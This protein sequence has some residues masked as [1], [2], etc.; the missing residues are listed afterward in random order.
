M[1][2]SPLRTIESQIADLK[3]AQ[4]AFESFG[5]AMARLAEMLLKMIEDV[6]RKFH[7]RLPGS[8]RTA[9]LRKKRR[10]KLIQWWEEEIWRRSE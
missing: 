1:S 4:K 9:R 3:S 10:K 2:E 6:Y 5:R 8:D 7:R